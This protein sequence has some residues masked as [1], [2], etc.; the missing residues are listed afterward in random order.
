MPSTGWCGAAVRVYGLGR[1]YGWGSRVGIP[2]EYYPATQLLEGEVHDS[3]A[4]PVRPTG[5][6]V[7]GHGARNARPATPPT[8]L[9]SGA[10]S[11]G[12]LPSPCKAASGPIRARFHVKYTKVSQ[13]AEVSPES[14][15]KA[16]HSPYLQNG[17]GISPLGFLRFPF[18]PAFSHKELLTLF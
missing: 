15:H 8:P 13:N 18:W 12:W 7:G 2:G 1:V 9:R 10:R 4:G 14:V 3:E 6:G 5:P 11:A 16:C 17:L